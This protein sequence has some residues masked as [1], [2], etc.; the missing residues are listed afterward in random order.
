MPIRV[1]HPN[2][3]TIEFPDGTDDATIS[4]VMRQVDQET[5]ARNRAGGGG[6]G[7]NIG[8]DVGRSPAA[9]RPLSQRERQQIGTRAI[10]RQTLRQS[11]P[12]GTGFLAVPLSNMTMDPARRRNVAESTQRLVRDVQSI[13]SLDWGRVARETGDNISQGVRDLPRTLGGIFTHLPEIGRAITYGPFEDE[14]RAQVRLELA[15]ALGDDSQ[16][17]HQAAEANRQTANAGLNVAAPV[18]FGAVRTIPQAAATAAALDAPFALSRNAE[19]ESLQERLPSA[20][21]EITGS[22]TFGGGAQA[23]TRAVPPISRLFPSRGARMVDRMD[24]AGASVDAQGNPVQPRG[25]TPSLATANS[26]VGVSGPAT[27]MVGDNLLGGLFTRGRVRRALTETRDAV[28]DVRDAYGR[29]QTRDAAGRRLQSGIERT[30]GERG[31]PNPRPGTDP[32]RVPV[33]EWSA[34]SKATAVFDQALRPIEGNAAQLTATQAELAALLQ[35]ADSPLVRA[36]N[37]DPVLSRLRSTVQ[38]L[39]NKAQ[40]GGVGAT[41][42]DLR[43]LRRGVREAQGRVRIGPDSVDNAALQRIEAA[44]TRDIYAAA[45][46]RASALQAADR[47]YARS[48]RRIDGLR[49]AI[50]PNNPAAMFNQIRRA[51]DPRTE[52]LRFL[53]AVRSALPD[54]EWRVFVASLIDDMGRP[55]NGAAGFTVEQGFSVETFAT[56]MRG[57]T[58]RAR[59]I[60]FGS[61]GGQG[62]AQAQTMRTLAADLDNLAEVAL[63]QKG[64]ERAANFSGSG[65]D[66]QNFLTFGVGV[67]NPAAGAGIVGSMLITGEMLTNPAFVRWLVSARRAGSPSGMRHQLALLRDLATRDPALLPAVADLEARLQ[68]QQYTPAPARA[69]DPGRTP[70]QR[71]P[72]LQ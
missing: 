40:R 1:V 59:Q 14:E 32:L 17:E 30:V 29:A 34:A 63:A 57:M 42:R 19:T 60:V 28:H 69:A 13:P 31:L 23:I 50:D 53:A 35:R 12:F 62:G 21:T 49:R 25:V 52:N 4:R 24:R 55:A 33:R 70:P 9:S 38:G 44:L 66:A 71:E 48:M 43:E 15:R 37:A 3:E 46:P 72:A 2:G 41:L 39:V 8:A 54:D 64:V 47:Y 58:P 67:S 27:K 20:T 10:V 61:R 26:G 11:A 51:A 6:V 7:A 36:F 65:R 68:D 16:V 5:D 18:A 22:A 45:G 56:A